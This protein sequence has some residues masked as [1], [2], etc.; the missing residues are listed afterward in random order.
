[1]REDKMVGWHH[2]INGQAFEQAP[3]DGK[4]Q[5]RLACFSPWGLKESDTTEA[6]DNNKYFKHRVQRKLLKAGISLSHP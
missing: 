5:G 6:Q 4:G 3:G 2:R 1:M